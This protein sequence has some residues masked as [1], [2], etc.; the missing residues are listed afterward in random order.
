VL[1]AALTALVR[2][3]QGQVLSA[4]VSGAP[5]LQVGTFA[6][7]RSLGTGWH[8]GISGRLD[9]R[10]RQFGLQVDAGMASS[11][12]EEGT[13][14][15]QV[16]SWNAGAGAFYRFGKLSA[17]VR[18]YAVLGIGVYYVEEPERNLITPAWNA[19]VGAEVGTGAIRAFVEARYHYVFTWGSD[20][21]YI[22]LMLGVR[23][24]F[25]P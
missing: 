23:Y 12:Y 5:V 10:S 22:P 3:V 13:R 1:A 25:N 16:Q 17:A 21:Q 24:A 4:G 14:E 9:Q 19:G 8:V 11:P 15:G 6:D 2:P 18:P 7:G 20:L